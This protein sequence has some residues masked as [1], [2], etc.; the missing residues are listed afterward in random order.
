MDG[1]SAVAGLLSL[2]ITLCKSLVG[3]CQDWASQDGEVQH[4]AQQLTDLQ[5]TLRLF[6]GPIS[7]LHSGSTAT[8]AAHLSMLKSHLEEGG[9]KLQAILDSCQT[10]QATSGIKEKIQRNAKKALYPFKKPKIEEIKHAVDELRANLALA[11]DGL[12]L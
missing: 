6:E 5:H 7:Q 1:A 12:Q 4:A 8:A 9:R 11:N 10:G 2:A 3:Y